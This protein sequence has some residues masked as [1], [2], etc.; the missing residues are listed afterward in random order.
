[1]TA[2]IRWDS[3]VEINKTIHKHGIRVD[4]ANHH[5]AGIQNHQQQHDRFHFV[6]LPGAVGEAVGAGWAQQGDVR[7]VITAP[8][9]E[10]DR[11]STVVV[12]YDNTIDEHN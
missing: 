1:V 6:D 2:S 10:F 8:S 4:D 7:A 11:V 9:N 5:R 12:R 3:W